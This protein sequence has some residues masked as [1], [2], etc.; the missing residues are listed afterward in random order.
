MKDL[1]EPAARARLPQDSGRWTILWR[2]ARRFQSIT[3]GSR[4]TSCCGSKLGCVTS[5][6]TA[7]TIKG[8]A[9]GRSVILK[10]FFFTLQPRGLQS[11]ITTPSWDFNLYIHTYC[12]II[13]DFCQTLT[14]RLQLFWD[15]SCTHL[16]YIDCQSKTC[17]PTQHQTVLNTLME[18]ELT[19]W[20][21]H[22]QGPLRFH[23]H[24]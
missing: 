20:S 1:K 17:L 24:L 23:Q 14:K 7:K 5:D 2:K 21:Q 22:R 19:G 9:C 16:L 11:S 18:G 6:W 4:F 13:Y 8:L 12:Y 3:I 10:P 15:A